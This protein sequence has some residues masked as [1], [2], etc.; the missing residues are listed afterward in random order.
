MHRRLLPF[1]LLSCFA[2]GCSTV[3][4]PMHGS[5]ALATPHTHLLHLPG[6]GGDSPFDRWWIAALRD[7][8][9]A[10]DVQLYDWTGRD[11]WIHALQA[12]RQNLIEA[13]KIADRIASQVRSDR[14]G[15]FILTSVSGGAGPAVWALERLPADVQVQSVV[16]AAPALSP[17]YDLTAALRHVR[18][19]VYVFTSPG[20]VF[21]LG[22]GT[23]LFGTIDGVKTDAAGLV[24]FR[25]PFGGD[26]AQYRKLVML[27]YNS[28]WLRYFNFGDHSGAMSV[29]FARNFIAPLLRHA[30]PDQT[31][32][33]PTLRSPLP[34]GE[35]SGLATARERDRVRAD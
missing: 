26:L 27:P 25:R 35:A 33:S 3:A 32:R 30:M 21:M 20:D 13:Q 17:G 23:K 28:E 15:Q 24:G 19:K 8:G 4:P 7:G 14:A 1:C 12:R 11:K 18:G 2:A 31:A 6:I 29:S 9:A 34:P 5:S 16:L 22:A 10:D